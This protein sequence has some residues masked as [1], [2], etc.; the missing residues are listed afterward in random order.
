M[1]RDNLKQFELSKVFVTIFFHM[2]FCIVFITDC[3]IQKPLFKIYI[4]TSIRFADLKNT[5]YFK[6]Y[7]L[8]N[9]TLL[10]FFSCNKQMHVNMSFFIFSNISKLMIFFSLISGRL[11][12][13]PEVA[14]G[15]SAEFQLSNV[16][17]L[18]EKKY[19]NYSFFIIFLKTKTN[20]AVI[21]RNPY[22]M[23]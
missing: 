12:I 20:Y 8:L 6:Y 7:Q 10:F 13:I 11:I 9:G 14:L 16:K 5:N 15:Y 19:Q 21:K 1:S 3:Q 17:R 22:Q 2:Y 18:N 4:I 23:F